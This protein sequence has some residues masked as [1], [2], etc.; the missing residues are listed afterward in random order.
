MK[1]ATK[2]KTSTM[3]LGLVALI[4]AQG[5]AKAVPLTMEGV[6]GNLNDYVTFSIPAHGS[7]PAFNYSSDESMGFTTYKVGSG[8]LV[9]SFCMDP[10]TTQTENYT[11]VP[12]ASGPE[13]S[14]GSVAMGS[15][16]ALAIEKLWG[17]YYSSARANAT[18]A[19]EL[20]LAIW[21]EVAESQGGTVSA[22]FYQ[23]QAN[24]MLVD[25]QSYSGSLPPLFAWSNNSYQDYIGVP[26]GG[27][28]ALL[29]GLGLTGVAA[30]RRRYF[31]PQRP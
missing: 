24:D 11:A 10:S 8:P 3:M 16:A 1:T 14:F 23:T 26:D 5:A 22:V 13:S 19:A 2:S 29:L 9:Y 27:T 30:V 18:V 7:T 12:L 21:T 17:T 6:T 28:T 15:T 20:Q 31:P 4:M 25:S